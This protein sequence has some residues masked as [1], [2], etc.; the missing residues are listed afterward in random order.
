MK[1][2]TAK[3]HEGMLASSSKKAWCKRVTTQVTWRTVAAA[4]ED[5]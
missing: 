2:H 4:R 1:F 3:A 5:R